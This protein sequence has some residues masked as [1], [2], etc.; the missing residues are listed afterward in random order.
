MTGPDD[1]APAPQV[2]S[3]TD[4]TICL[5]CG[6]SLRGLP[7]GHNCP[8]CGHPSDRE[9]AR[10]EV[11]DLINQPMLKLGWRMLQFWKLL[12][13]G[14]WWV[15]DQP[16]DRREARQRTWKWILLSSLLMLVLWCSIVLVNR[17]ITVTKYEHPP[18]EPE[19]KQL[20]ASASSSGVMSS[21]SLEVAPSKPG[22]VIVT[23]RTD[24]VVVEFR[25]GLIL[26]TAFLITLII[27]L[28]WLMMR[29]LWLPI[30]L[31]TG[32][33]KK[34]ASELQSIKTIALYQYAPMLMLFLAET[35]LLWINWA[36][37]TS[38]LIHESRTI[39]VV[40]VVLS[41]ISLIG[42]SWAAAIKS[43]RTGHIFEHKLLPILGIMLAGGPG[44][45]LAML[46]IGRRISSFFN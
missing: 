1:N 16:Q 30:C 2:L 37:Y 15:L 31:A 11:L 14:W 10:Q 5:H 7:A 41:H 35:L 44:G 25:V 4:L 46:L 18:G 13:A 26:Q 22:W 17:N 27:F 12:P 32:P 40:V 39:V 36:L 43:D 34:S 6:Y 21:F 38:G 29:W 33:R 9:S 28:T 45:L 8:E 23:E 19:K 42:T 24:E 3:D 20:R